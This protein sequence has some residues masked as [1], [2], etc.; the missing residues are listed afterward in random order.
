MKKKSKSI[1]N[2][3][4]TIT[5]KINRSTLNGASFNLDTQVNGDFLPIAYYLF[6][7]SKLHYANGIVKKIIT[8]YNTMREKFESIFYLPFRSLCL[9]S[10]GHFSIDHTEECQ[11]TD[12]F[13]FQINDWSLTYLCIQLYIQWKWSMYLFV[14]LICTRYLLLNSIWWKKG[15]TFSIISTKITG[16]IILFLRK[17]KMTYKSKLHNLSVNGA[18]K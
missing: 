17:I 13:S 10:T 5:L 16:C 3:C 6:V 15:K 4:L 18:L 8:S 14:Q 11:V 9:K 12:T 1:F 2:L 7:E